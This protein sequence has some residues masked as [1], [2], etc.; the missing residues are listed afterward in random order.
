MVK[1]YWNMQYILPLLKFLSIWNVY[2][3]TVW[4]PKEEERV[5][6]KISKS[7]SRIL[8]LTYGQQFPTEYVYGYQYNGPLVSLT[9]ILTPGG[10]DWN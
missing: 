8:D 7:H 4:V 6:I 3:M 9:T 5:M 1:Q 2:G 10:Q